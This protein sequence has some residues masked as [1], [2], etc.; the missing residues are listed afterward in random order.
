M[1]AS[2]KS[3]RANQFLFREG[4]TAGSLFVVKSGTISIRKRKGSG[5]IELS[6]AFENEVVG[7]L[8]FFDQQPRSAAAM[9]LTEVEV[10][11]I[12][13]DGLAS[14]YEAV[15]DYFKTMI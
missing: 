2:I 15:P 4:D 13:F 8:S 11:E 5:F 14:V 10:L 12:T 1:S 3:F 7:E 6:R 9:A